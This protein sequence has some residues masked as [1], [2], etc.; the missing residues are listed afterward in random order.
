MAKI[1]VG[2]L[3]TFKASY[4]GYFKDLRGMGFTIDRILLDKGEPTRVTLLEID[5]IHLIGLHNLELLDN[6][7]EQHASA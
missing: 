4:T 5:E 3:V 6:S 7:G 1:T 2:S